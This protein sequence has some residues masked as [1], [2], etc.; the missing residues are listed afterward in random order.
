MG[1]DEYETIRLIDFEGFS[2]AQCAAKMD[3][4]RTT[5]T[6]MYANARKK[7]ADALVHGR[8]LEISGGDVAV[9]TAFKPECAGM[10]GCCHKVK[11]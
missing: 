9:C 2:Q 4:A 6:R 1:Y 11:Q 8:Q 10:E 5:V 3:V 7:L